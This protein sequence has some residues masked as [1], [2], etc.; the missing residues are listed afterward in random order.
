MLA[1]DVPFIVR[2]GDAATRNERNKESQFF[3]SFFLSLYV[4]NRLIDEVLMCESNFRGEK[5]GRTFILSRSEE[6]YYRSSNFMARFAPD[7]LH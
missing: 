1:F 3:L 5:R 4:Q 6:F 7:F 2:V